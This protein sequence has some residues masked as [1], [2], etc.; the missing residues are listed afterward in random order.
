MIEVIYIR[1]GEVVGAAAVKGV[2]I[3]YIEPGDRGC[4]LGIKIADDALWE[5][6]YLEY[7]KLREYPEYRIEITQSGV[8]IGVLDYMD[9]RNKVVLIAPSYFLTFLRFVI[10][11]GCAWGFAD[12]RGLRAFWIGRPC[13]CS[14]LK[15]LVEVAI[16]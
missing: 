9:G 16:R 3:L 14:Y 4:L 8:T 7:E 2:D 13:P 12:S 10:E 6:M 1:G 5:R 11:K 15:R